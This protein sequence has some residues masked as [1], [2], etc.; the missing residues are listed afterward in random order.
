MLLKQGSRVCIGNLQSHLYWKARPL[1]Y[2]DPDGKDAYG[3]SVIE[4]LENALEGK[5][6]SFLA[7]EGDFLLK[8]CRC[9]ASVLTGGRSGTLPLD[10]NIF[11]DHTIRVPLLVVEWASGGRHGLCAG[12]VGIY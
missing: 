9:L 6:G 2:E 1:A 8:H 7:N 12:T 3:A 4:K 10:R 11:P 5:H